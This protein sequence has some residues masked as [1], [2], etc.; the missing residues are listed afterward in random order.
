MVISIINEVSLQ[1]LFILLV[2]TLKIVKERLFRFLGLKSNVL[3]LPIHIT[4]LRTKTHSLKQ[5]N[6]NLTSYHF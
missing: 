6:I 5:N 3:E 4:I 1:I 2:F